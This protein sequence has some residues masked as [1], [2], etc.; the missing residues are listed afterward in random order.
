MSI[1][2]LQQL[3]IEKKNPTVVGLDP[4]PEY[5]PPHI[6]AEHMAQKGETL[7]AAADAFYAFNCGLIDTLADIVPAVKPQSAYY[8]LLGPAGVVALHNTVAY[9]KSKGLYVILDGKRND[10]GSTAAAYSDAYLGRVTVGNTTYAP[11]DADSLTVNA[12]LGSDGLRPFLE[13]C[14]TFDKSIFAL[15]KTSNPSSGELQDLR[16]G[17]STLY[18]VVGDLLDHL[19]Q[20]SIGICGYSNLGAVVGATYPAEAKALRER[21]PHTFFLVPGYGAQGGG[22]ADVAPCFAEGGRGAVVNSSRAIMCAWKKTT[23]GDGSDYQEAARAEAVRMQQDIAGVV[24][25]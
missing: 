21:L 7:E 16:I 4:R 14:K 20:D 15:V 18:T 2:R 5:I 22:A 3:I 6:L 10:I 12:Y 25:V 8:E 19:G 24:G 17:D 13:T 23:T 9:A 11:F 1:D